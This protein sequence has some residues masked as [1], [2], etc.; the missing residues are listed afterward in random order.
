MRTTGAC[1]FPALLVL[2][3]LV[4]V[5]D[6]LS[7]DPNTCEPGEAP[8]LIVGDI[9]AV[10][11]FGTVDGRTSFAFGDAFCN[12]GTCQASWNANTPEHPVIAQNVYRL[13]HGRFEQ[14]GL[15]WARH[16]FFPLQQNLC[17]PNCQP[18]NGS[19]GVMCS[20][21]NSG[22]IEGYQP[23][24]GPRSEVDPSS[25]AHLHPFTS[26]NESGDA[27]YKRLRVAEAE[28]DPTTHPGAR[29]FA[30]VQI[31]AH[32]DAA[33]GRA[34]DNASWRELTVV[35]VSG[36]LG[37]QLAGTTSRA[38]PALAAWAASD[39]A[40]VA[41]VVETGEGVLHLAARA[42]STGDGRWDY[43]YA[44]H[45]ATSHRGVGAFRVPFPQATAAS[46]AAFHD[47]DYHSDEIYDGTDWA[48]DVGPSAISW[49]TTPFELD[50]NANALR[51]G[52]LYN[53]R[54]S[55]DVPPAS[56]LVTVGLFRPGSPATIDVQSLVPRWCDGEELA[57]ADGI[58]DDCD[59]LADCTDAACCDAAGCDGQDLDGDLYEACDCDDGTAAVWHAPG[60]VEELLLSQADGTT[61]LG[62]SAAFE[63]GAATVT[64][65]TLRSTDAADFVDG[66]D[67]LVA[68]DPTSI[69]LTDSISPPPGTAFFYLTR[70]LN[71]CPAGVGSLGPGAVNG[72]RQGRS[73]P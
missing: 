40:V 22:A 52:T 12:L 38:E 10:T 31:V 43:E 13:E 62:W 6:A 63:P 20:T 45:N 16:G 50:P 54:F 64:Y 49:S 37:F 42:T 44:V 66:A 60:E 2:L 21:P 15:G 36:G 5:Q 34:D 27:V 41:T 4:P 73:C 58:D 9:N 35:P 30:E 65:E 18:A 47:V 26:Q 69:E 1:T 61:T 56:G 53:F 55:A 33:A 46:D 3:L 11:R 57:C 29:W 14:L 68:P 67:C 17:S 39:P 28:L 51:W 71:G 23:I 59:A 70:A 32:D 25:G 19:L 72:P 48:I 8:N 7:Q 24:L